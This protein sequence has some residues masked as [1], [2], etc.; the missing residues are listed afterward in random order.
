LFLLL[1][2]YFSPQSC[3]LPAA[4]KTAIP[5]TDRQFSGNILAILAV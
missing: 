1:S 5:V 2:S 3:L 4:K